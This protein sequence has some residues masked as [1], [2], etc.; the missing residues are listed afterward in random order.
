[1][2]AATLPRIQPDMHATESTAEPQLDLAWA[3]AADKR[4]PLAVLRGE[5][6]VPKDAAGQPMVYFA[7]HSLGPQPRNV[8]TYV[9]ETLDDWQEFAVEGHF[10][11]RHPWLSYHELLTASTARLVGALPSEVVVMNTLSVNLHLLMCSFYRPTPTRF[12]ILVEAGAFPSDQYAVASQAVFHGYDPDQAVVALA[13]R[14]GESCLREEELLDSI[15]RL[16]PSTALVLLGTC[17]YLTGQGFPM[18]AVVEAG[19]AQGCRVGFDLAHGAGNLDCQLH[20]T[21]ADF[22]VWCNYKYL[23]AGPGGLGGAFVHERHHQADL[24]RFA[25]WWGHDKATRFQMGPRFHAIAGAE[26]WQL[27]NPP[28][29]QLAALRA[30]MEL[31]DRAGIGALR[32][33]GEQLSEYLLAWLDALPAGSMALQTPRD[34]RKRGTMLT[35]RL[36]RAGELVAHLR[37]R[38]IAVDLRAPDIVRLTP[39]PLYCGHA[40]VARAGLALAEFFAR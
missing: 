17:N 5:F 34:S 21:G 1:M 30:S 13:P 10:M 16:G 15:G 27:S 2:S 25:G 24:P 38:G 36:E 22:A 28:I 33:K 20:A 29:L 19:H 26:G 35:M 4:D 12:R 11:G 18:R 14:P 9:N 8:R 40:D 37:E 3:E 7:G 39:A 23:N 32:A 31:F 6:L